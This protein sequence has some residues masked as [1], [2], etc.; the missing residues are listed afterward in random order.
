MSSNQNTLQFQENIE[1][2]T[3][4]EINRTRL[5]ALAVKEAISVASQ[6]DWEA[7]CRMILQHKLL[8]WSEKNT[9]VVPAGHL[10]EQSS[11]C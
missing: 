3:G 5:V 11:Y 10:I 9:I 7:A 1:A 4:N 2:E 8:T 6:Q